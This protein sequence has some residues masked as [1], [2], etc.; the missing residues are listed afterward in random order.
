MRH[1]RGLSPCRKGTYWPRWSRRKRYKSSVR[2][3]VIVF[4]ATRPRCVFKVRRR[5]T[6]R[7]R[8]ASSLRAPPISASNTLVCCGDRAY[9]AQKRRIFS[10][11]GL[12]YHPIHPPHPALYGCEHASQD[13]ARRKM[14]RQLSP[15]KIKTYES[16]RREKF[17]EYWHGS[18]PGGSLERSAPPEPA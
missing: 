10:S 4:W 11:S 8:S 2:E 12:I 5:I 14:L 18:I 3:R 6:R 17:G 9:S 7:R 16:A 15:A 13:R 1:G